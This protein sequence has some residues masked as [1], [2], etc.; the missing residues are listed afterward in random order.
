MNKKIISCFVLCYIVDIVSMNNALSNI[1]QLP[2]DVLQLIVGRFYNE[3]IQKNIIIPF[4]EDLLFVKSEE[5]NTIIRR[6]LEHYEKKHKTQE[7]DNP[8]VNLMV[9]SKAMVNNCFLK[10]Y[11]RTLQ[12]DL[13]NLADFYEDL[14]KFAQ[15]PCCKLLFSFTE[16]EN[17]F[18]HCNKGACLNFNK[19]NEVCRYTLQFADNVTHYNVDQSIDPLSLLP[20]YLEGLTGKSK[21][22]LLPFITWGSSIEKKRSIND[23][24]QIGSHTW[25]FTKPCYRTTDFYKPASEQKVKGLTFATCEFSDTCSLHSPFRDDVNTIV[26]DIFFN[27]DNNPSLNDWKPPFPVKLFFELCKLKKA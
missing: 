25:S 2:A 12:I 16:D 13:I 10:K 4:N 17:G 22:S 6:P 1:E 18:V 5:N 21:N 9:T 24:E 19:I 23:W 14:K 8:I 7:N 20:D 26:F 27:I 3:T 11:W 15:V